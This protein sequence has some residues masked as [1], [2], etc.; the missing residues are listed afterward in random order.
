V[1]GSIAGFE[2]NYCGPVVAWFEVVK[3]VRS[4]LGEGELLKSSAISHVVHV[5]SLARSW[6]FWGSMV[7]LNEFW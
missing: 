3:I 5:D 1:V 6:P 2:V 7:M 4:V